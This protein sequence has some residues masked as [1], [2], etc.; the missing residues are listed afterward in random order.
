M[1]NELKDKFK[2][3][4]PGLLGNLRGSMADYVFITQHGETVIRT[5]PRPLNPMDT[6][7]FAQSTHREGFKL[8]VNAYKSIK[9]I[10]DFA[11]PNR[12]IGLSSYNAFMTTNFPTAIDNSGDAPIVDYSKLMVSKGKLPKVTVKSAQ[13]DDSGIKIMYKSLL[14]LPIISA[15]DQIVAFVKL[16]TG[17][18]ILAKQARGY[19]E[20]AAIFIPL[21]GIS[22]E[23]V[24][25]CYLFVINRD[26]R[27]ASEST[28]VEIRNEK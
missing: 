1:K 20:S 9:E 6:K 15:S 8:M 26:G 11:F 5:K 13:L 3:S 14:T 28:Y 24:E 4:L 2:D 10:V 25:C 16:K 19:E 7:S 21:Q 27:S 17:E 22:S 12:R 18:L 23:E